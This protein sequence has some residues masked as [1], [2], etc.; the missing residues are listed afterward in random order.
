V[1][2]INPV[3]EVK[4]LSERVRDSS[5]VNDSVKLGSV[6]PDNVE[7]EPTSLNAVLPAVLDTTLVLVGVVVCDLFSL[8]D[9]SSVEKVVPVLDL[10]L[11]VRRL[12]ALDGLL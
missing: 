5:T 2:G 12:P 1:D 10:A 4:L 3:S 7:N 6:G 11:G 9:P 8:S